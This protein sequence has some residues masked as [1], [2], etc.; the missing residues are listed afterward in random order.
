MTAAVFA[1]LGVADADA[2]Q[3]TWSVW[4]KWET[5]NTPSCSSPGS[6]VVINHGPTAFS[7][8][9]YHLIGVPGQP[10]DWTGLGRNFTP[11]AGRSCTAFAAYDSTEV[12]TSVPM[13]LEVIDGPS[14]T[15][16]HNGSVTNVPQFQSWTWRSGSF[17]SN[18]NQ[19]HVR[20]VLLGTSG[21]ANLHIDDIV[22]QCT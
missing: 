4:E 22:V 5:G 14:W 11:P 13:K 19:I 21:A 2:Q 3:I 8:S 18:G 10:S 12:F 16:L 6:C 7:P 17:T 9:R 20:V 1:A 15:Y